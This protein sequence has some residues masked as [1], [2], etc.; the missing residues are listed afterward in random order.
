MFQIYSAIDNTASY[1]DDL[2]SKVNK[3]LIFFLFLSLSS[4]PFQPVKRKSLVETLL[5][6]PLPRFDQSQQVHRSDSEVSQSQGSR[7][8]SS[9]FPPPPPLE[10]P[11]FEIPEQE[12]E[13]QNVEVE[14]PFVYPG[15]DPM[16]F[17]DNYDVSSDASDGTTPM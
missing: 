7:R 12:P 3:S 16:Q 1:L 17:L 10:E 4:F 15:P 13:V 9:T 6:Q 5:S 11:S 14:E 2:K 8:S